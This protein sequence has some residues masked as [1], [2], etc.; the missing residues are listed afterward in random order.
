M[1]EALA[2]LLLT[3]AR[4]TSHAE[5]HQASAVGHDRVLYTGLSEYEE[6]QDRRAN[7]IP[8]LHKEVIEG[9]EDITSELSMPA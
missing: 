5:R 1:L 6:E 4:D 2:T 7:G 8:L 9:F 3:G